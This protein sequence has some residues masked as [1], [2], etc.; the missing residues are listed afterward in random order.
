MEG[1][2]GRLFVA[3]EELLTTYLLHTS[4]GKGWASFLERDSCVS[5]CGLWQMYSTLANKWLFN[6]LRTSCCCCPSRIFLPQPN[7]CANCFAHSWSIYSTSKLSAFSDQNIII[8]VT[9][10]SSNRSILC[11]C[12]NWQLQLQEQET[13]IFYWMSVSDSSFLF[14]FELFL[15]H[16]EFNLSS[17]KRWR[18]VKWCLTSLYSC[19]RRTIIDSDFVKKKWKWKWKQQS[20]IIN[21]TASRGNLLRDCLPID[22]YFFREYKYEYKNKQTIDVLDVLL[23]QA[24]LWQNQIYFCF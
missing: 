14:F 11:L 4:M 5:M 21:S 15:L 24:Q 2:S 10:P 9:Q 20:D 7:H 13:K 12:C 19:L 23:I 17:G 3:V 1:K 18:D 8:I 6:E 16:K 22:P